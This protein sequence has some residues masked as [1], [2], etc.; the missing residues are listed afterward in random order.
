MLL[1]A[2]TMSMCLALPS[3]AEFEQYW[4]IGGGPAGTVTHNA[5]PQI[6]GLGPSFPGD[7]TA[8]FWQFRTA[9]T[10]GG[11][12]TG[13]FQRSPSALSA[14]A[15]GFSLTANARSAAYFE[16][17]APTG[18]SV[19]GPNGW[20][21]NYGF[22][23]SVDIRANGVSAGW[24]DKNGSHIMR[25]SVGLQAAD[26][27]PW[28]VAIMAPGDKYSFWIINDS[29]WPTQTLQIQGLI[30]PEPSSMAMGALVGL[31]ALGYGVR[32]WRSTKC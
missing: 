22:N 23:W 29:D 2:G 32:R 13:E 25:N 26:N 16:I 30:V 8:P 9:A 6:T 11:G 24:V 1:A 28:N 21:E 19:P 18:P 5:G 15:V 17:N 7:P 4:A 12:G 31:G 3:L 10:A 14:S 20:V 27:Q